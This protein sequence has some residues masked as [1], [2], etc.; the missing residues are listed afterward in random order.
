LPSERCRQRGFYK[1]TLDRD[2]AWHCP[3]LLSFNSK[4]A[5]FCVFVGSGHPGRYLAAVRKT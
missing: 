4:N 1:M 5:G 3:S 2:S